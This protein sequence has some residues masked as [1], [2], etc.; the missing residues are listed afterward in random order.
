MDDPQRLRQ[1]RRP[2]DRCPTGLNGQAYL[3]YGQPN[4]LNIQLANA[5]FNVQ[6]NLSFIP[7]TAAA[8]ANK[9][10]RHLSGAVFTG[11][12]LNSLSGFAVASAGDFNSDGFG[13]ILIGSPGQRAFHR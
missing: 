4:L 10:Q 1:R 12:G 5:N 2:A 3:I 13:D 8:I 7:L 9:A 11:Y 6:Q